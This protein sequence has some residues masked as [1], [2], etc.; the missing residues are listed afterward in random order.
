MSAN[1]QNNI[2]VSCYNTNTSVEMFRQVMFFK[3]S[4]ENICK[5]CRVLG[6]PRGNIL[7]LGE[8]PAGGGPEE[9]DKPES[10]D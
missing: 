9:L 5:I 7:L 6:Q 3:Y 2:D 10:T 1:P 4:M 8:V